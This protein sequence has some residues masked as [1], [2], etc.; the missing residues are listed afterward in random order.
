[1][2]ATI[3]RTLSA[4]LAVSLL[5]LLLVAGTARA[6][7]WTQSAAGGIDGTYNQ[8]QDS[9]SCSTMF[10]DGSGIQGLFVGTNNFDGT[11]C[12]VWRMDPG[13][14]QWLQVNVDG[15][16][17]PNNTEATS[18]CAFTNGVAATTYLYVGT[19]NTV[20]G[21]EL[22]RTAGLGG[23]PYTDWVQVNADGF[24]SVANTQISSM[25]DFLNSRLYAG[26]Q[27]AGGAAT[28][29]T[30]EVG[31]PP[32][33]DWTLNLLPSPLGTTNTDAASMAVFTA[34]GTLH[35]GTENTATGCE[36]WQVSAPGVAPFRVDA[37]PGFPGPWPPAGGFGNPLNMKA[38]S[39]TFCT[40]GGNP[41]LFV[42]TE[43]Q[44]TGCEVYRTQTFPAVPPPNTW[45]IDW[46]RV[47][48]PP[49]PLPP[50][51]GGF[52]NAANIEATCMVE[53]TGVLYVGTDNAALT[54]GELYWSAG[55]GGPP[56]AD[57]TFNPLPGLDGDPNNST[58]TCMAQP[59]P[60]LPPLYLGTG[61]KIT[62]AEMFL[63]PAIMALPVRTNFNGFAPNNCE[64]AAPMVEF[65]GMLHVGTV[66]QTTGC[67]VWAYDG[68]AWTQVNDDGFTSFGGNDWNMAVTSMTVCNFGGVD[69]LFV[70]T[71]N[72]VSGCQLW[73]TAG[74][75]GPP[76]ADW[77][78]VNTNGFGGTNMGISSMATFSHGGTDYL[79]VGTANVLGGCE[80]WE[81][82]GAGGP[83]FA[84]WIQVN[85][86]GFVLPPTPNNSAA[87][88]MEEFGG[89]LYAGTTN[90]GG[91]EV[92][93]TDCTGPVPYTW[94]QANA[95][96]FGDANNQMVSSMTADGSYLYAGTQNANGCSVLRT[97]GT[98]GPP[99]A[100][101]PVNTAGFGDTNNAAA[102]S[103]T[104]FDGG[105]YVGTGNT[106][107]AN[108]AQVWRT[109][110]HGAAPFTWN[111]VNI[112]GF[113]N[114]DNVQCQSL[115]GYGSRLY[116]GTWNFLD[117]CEVWRVDAPAVSGANPAS[118]LQGRT[119]N[120]QISGTDSHFVNG[121]SQAVFGGTGINVNSTTVT[122]PT[123]ATANI[124]ISPTAAAGA[125]SVTVNTGGESATLAGAFTVNNAVPTVTG[126]TP[127]TAP[128]GTTVDVTDL[129]GTNFLAG[130]T[131]RL[132]KG[133]QPDIVAT[134]VSVASL[135]KMTCRFAVPVTAATGDWD[136]YVEN[137]NGQGGTLAGGFQVAQTVE[138][139][140]YLAE[141]STDW[142]FGT[143]ISIENPNA[144]T[145][146][147]D[148]TYMPTGSSNQNQT[149]TLPP[150]SRLTVDPGE[151]LGSRDFSTK[152]ECRQGLT[153]AV[154]RT[155]E[156]LGTGATCPET[157]CSIGVTSPA[158]DW[159]L[160]EGSSDWGFE[161]WL[162]IQNPNG[163][164]ADCDITYM[165]EGAEPVTVSKS[166]PANSRATF[167]M[168]DDIGAEDASIRVQSDVPVIPE[169]AMYR[170]NR[171]EGH[172]SIG[173]TAAATSYYLAEGTSAWGFTTYVL[174]Q[175]PQ[176]SEN[177][178]NVTYMTDSGLVPH[179]ENPI[180]MPA[181]SRKT[182]RVNDFL[183]TRD[184]STRVDGDKPI[185]AERAMY[186]DNG[187]GEACHDSIGMNAPHNTFFLPDGCVGSDV[188]T[189]TLVQNP[190]DSDVEITVTYLSGTG[191]DPIS[192]IDTVQANSRKTFNMAD[193]GVAG[194]AGVM[195][196]SDTPG[197]NIMVERAM[198]W[199]D[200]GA[201]T[202]TIGGY[203]D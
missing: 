109:G 180:I 106:I 14:G 147:C 176:G 192:F 125:R 138:D 75:G 153:I 60:G 120:V 1:M 162:L 58:I 199:Y 41:Y 89:Y 43:N 25:A 154:D 19:R 111:Q 172:D 28:F 74:A 163:S 135:T 127:A 37:A 62:G 116:A 177:S 158:T 50:G 47:D 178:V 139:T 4:V 51:P 79:Q 87:S 194:Q 118:A 112:D 13:T 187:T 108:G 38:S 196:T 6:D 189:W 32:Y 36:V 40:L 63:L 34:G 190:N 170:N 80:V 10:T 122:G 35:V 54:G 46:T 90:S 30:A 188:E 197:K 22:W 140:W 93:R 9:A 103:L 126:I 65:K 95:A 96:G 166:V 160:P 175:N 12:E 198:Y 121:V 94:T 42:G 134:N 137:A 164:Q 102:Y 159:F 92:Y 76:Y 165:I 144:G 86:S 26:V 156:W 148:I 128:K 69:Y 72:L 183:P 113:G 142:G 131:V 78:Q 99:P 133:G 145:V 182:I 15:F 136:V 107:T 59:G 186:W 77:V 53:F 39:M 84:D 98:G 97:D 27:N 202:D 185:I 181:N 83:P 200:R 33:T 56:Y 105:L 16:G 21:C 70:G 174:I 193:K 20:T 101:T 73:R 23:P 61:N 104:F 129:A 52:G 81:T 45:Y 123:Q 173:T 66:N 149:V 155:M 117:G 143:Y 132:K 115:A 29:D 2:R 167:N 146:T 91:C 48:A 85:S 8:F 130:A 179:P 88:A 49:A 203:A 31:A 169:R 114:P 150:M 17:D 157:H 7:T 195:V 168:D 5:A 151:L 67:K 110:L 82:A 119:L 68:A 18:I 64:T 201:G 11:G 24:G 71:L 191:A 124:T 100:W 57:W 171:R 152:V 184:F 55:V 3:R 141:G 161:C 44:Q